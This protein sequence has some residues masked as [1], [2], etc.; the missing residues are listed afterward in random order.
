MSL[1]STERLLSSALHQLRVGVHF[2]K[3]R[4]I[5][6]L[7]PFPLPHRHQGLFIYLAFNIFFREFFTLIS[8]PPMFG[9]IDTVTLTHARIF[10]GFC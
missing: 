5:D 6:Q 3:L 4:P 8:G 1:L 9:L 7:G 10:L 2:I